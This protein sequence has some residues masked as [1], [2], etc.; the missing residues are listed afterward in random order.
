M[1][2]RHVERLLGRLLTDEELRSAFIRNP[3]ETL[4]ALSTEGCELS[5]T[6]REALLSNPSV[7]R[8]LARQV[9]SRLQRCN[10]RTR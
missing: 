10:L 4:A 2:Q 9:P 5:P 6:E 8:E 3:Q 1:S 7:W